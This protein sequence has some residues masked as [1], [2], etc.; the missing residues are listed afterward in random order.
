M[1]SQEQVRV[2]MSLQRGISRTQMKKECYRRRVHCRELIRA[3]ADKRNAKSNT[4]RG[5]YAHISPAEAKRYGVHFVLRKI[6]DGGA[7]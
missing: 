3:I 1:F 6:F 5:N 7:A 4:I 2:A